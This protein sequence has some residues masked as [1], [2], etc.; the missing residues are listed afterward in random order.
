[1]RSM[2]ITLDED[3][4]ELMPEQAFSMRRVNPKET[5]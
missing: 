2:P 3:C 5:H 4:P 1:M